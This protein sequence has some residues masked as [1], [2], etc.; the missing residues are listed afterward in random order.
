MFPLRVSTTRIFR[1]HRSDLVQVKF[2]AF[3]TLFL[4]TGSVEPYPFSAG[5]ANVS[6]PEMDVPSQTRDSQETFMKKL[7]LPAI[8]AALMLSLL[9]P[10]AG[11]LCSRNAQAQATTTASLT[12]TVTDTQGAAISGAEVTL[13]EKA[14]NAV[15]SIKSNDS[16]YF[17]VDGLAAGVYSL[18][19]V[20]SGFATLNRP[21]L[22][23]SIGSVADVPISLPAASVQES[24]TVNESTPLLQ[25]EKTDVG[26]LINQRQ[27]QEI[28]VNGRNFV[29]LAQLNSQA[30][31]TISTPRQGVSVEVG[32]QRSYETSVLIDGFWNTD[33]LFGALRHVYSM[34]AVQEFQVITNGASAEYGRGLGGVVTA[35]TKSGTN[36]VHGSAFGYF[37]DKALNAWSISDKNTKVKQDYSRQQYG[38]TLGGAILRD[39]SFLFGSFERYNEKIPTDN[40]ITAANATA[41]G[42]PAEDVGA[43]PNLRK[44]N[45]WMVKYDQKITERQ[46][47]FAAF[48]RTNT[49]NYGNRSETYATRSRL[50]HQNFLD[51]SLQVGWQLVTNKWLHDIRGSYFPRDNNSLGLN[52]GN[53]PLVP[54]GSTLDQLSVPQVTI[55]N[56]ASFGKSNIANAQKTD[57]GQIIY[58][59]STQIGNHTI[60][61]GGDAMLVVYSQWQYSGLQGTYTFTNLANYQSGHYSTYSQVFGNPKQ[62]MHH[63]YLSGFVQDA[64][65]VNPRLA[66][67]L[68]L[69]YDVERQPR[70]YGVSYGHDRNNFGPRG[71]VSFDLLG[72]HKTLLKAS[73]ALFY[74]VTFLNFESPV[75]YNYIAS[76]QLFTATWNYGQ[77]GAPT[78]PNFYAT[79]PSTI[80]AGVRDVWDLPHDFKTPSSAQFNASIE[81][82]LPGKFLA[83]VTYLYSHTMD[84]VYQYDDNLAFNTTTN[85]W[86][87]PNATYRAIY[88]YKPLAKGTYSA[89]ILGVMKNARLYNLNANVTYA[90][91]ID[92]ETGFTDTINDQ[93]YPERERGPC[94]DTP[95]AR[96]VISGAYRPVRF[97]SFSG[98]FAGNTGLPYDPRVGSG[99]DTN[100]DG[101]FND[102]VVGYGRNSFRRKETNSLDFRVTGYVPFLKDKPLQIQAQAFNLL[103]HTNIT[104]VNTTYG[105]TVGSPLA[106]FGTA[107]TWGPKRQIELAARFNF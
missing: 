44:V 61:F 99:Y 13:T 76:P 36:T 3:Q 46:H 35:V 24:I 80:P 40:L 43:I 50:T 55:T 52:V 17:R 98:I 21:A 30:V 29:D 82:L 103:N 31:P 38:G 91:C 51:V 78:Y 10:G 93:R 26:M 41:I 4:I 104:G 85:A 64:W 49:E 88:E 22:E 45:F 53:L 105:P 20:K 89:G 74:D 68:G 12:G 60:K 15:R 59:A 83:T 84:Q 95:R 70:F 71:G 96:G 47:L 73:G 75:Y 63:S 86:Y 92:M 58:S 14:T 32:G 37:R 102:R 48:V 2:F 97:V 107:S 65:K 100:G 87:R 5:F 19:V 106:L 1:K 9:L 39:R 62:T 25:T 77:T 101:K 23:L 94:S 66:L 42:L 7:S 16:G 8:R 90:S 69:R 18:Q 57:P 72:N 54:A 81:Q 79:L 11:L 34:D 67:N 33:E 27:I 6:A 28:P 56:V